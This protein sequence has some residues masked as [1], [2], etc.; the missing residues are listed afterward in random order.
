MGGLWKELQ[1]TERPLE[2]PAGVF[3]LRA[4]ER[5]GFVDWVLYIMELSLRAKGQEEQQKQSTKYILWCDWRETA[6]RHG[7]WDVPA[8]KKRKCCKGAVHEG[9]LRAVEIAEGSITVAFVTFVISLFVTK[10]VHFQP[11][12]EL[13]L[14]SLLRESCILKQ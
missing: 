14:F 3:S 6:L 5:R 12:E 2:W 11:F 9:G 1:K 7:N 13:L 4:T 10:L 8:G